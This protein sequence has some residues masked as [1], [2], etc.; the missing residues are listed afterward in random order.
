MDPML[1]ALQDYAMNHKNIEGG[2]THRDYGIVFQTPDPF[3]D[4]VD[5]D[6]VQISGGDVFGAGD[7]AGQLQEVDKLLTVLIDEIDQD[8]TSEYEAI[9]IPLKQKKSTLRDALKTIII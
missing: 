2:G 9:V 7:I 5:D 6:S 4:E 1:E 3:Y 8:S